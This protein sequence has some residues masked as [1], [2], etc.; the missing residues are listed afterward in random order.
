MVVRG[1]YAVMVDM[2]VT[3]VVSPT[4]SNPPLAT[5]LTFA[6]NIRLSSAAS[7]ALASGLAPNSV[8]PDFQSGRTQTWNVN[9]ERQIGQSLGMMVGYFGSHGDRLR[10]SRNV[11]QPVNGVRPY[12]ALSRTSPIL[13]APAR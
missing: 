11:N 5:P 7:T 12:P 10:I 4:S 13:P 6:G 1:A 3:N 2:P 9:V 8:N